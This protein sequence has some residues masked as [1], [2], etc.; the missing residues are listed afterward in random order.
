MSSNFLFFFFFHFFFILEFYIQIFV[1]SINIKFH[2][3]PSSGSLVVP[4]GRTDGQKDKTKLV[5]ALRNFAKR[6]YTPHSRHT[7][8]LT[9]NTTTH[10]LKTL[11]WSRVKTP[12]LH[13][14]TDM[15]NPVQNCQHRSTYSFMIIRTRRHVKS[16]TQG[17]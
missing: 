9:K 7:G 4:C 3:N 17:I 16:L 13:H 12:L 15:T 1:N 10:P 8:D 14:P 2:E 6:A 5:V 11:V